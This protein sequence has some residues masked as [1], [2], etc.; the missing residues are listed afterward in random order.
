MVFFRAKYLKKLIIKHI[1][2]KYKLLKIFNFQKDHFLQEEWCVGRN[3]FV[4]TVR[5][6]PQPNARR[7]TD[8]PLKPIWVHRKSFT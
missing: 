4:N 5:Q 8:A 1:F 6:T 2:F 3:L 7:T